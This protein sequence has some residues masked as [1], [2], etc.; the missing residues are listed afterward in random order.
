MVQQQQQ[1]QQQQEVGPVL[2]NSVVLWR[3][4]LGRHAFPQVLHAVCVT[5][6]ELCWGARGLQSIRFLRCCMQR[7]LLIGVIFAVWLNCA[8]APVARNP[9][10]L[11]MC[12]ILLSRWRRSS[13]CVELCWN[14][15]GLESMLFPEVLHAFCSPRGGDLHCVWNC[16]GAPVAWNPGDSSGVTCILLSL[17]G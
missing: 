13:L 2:K 1:Q 15:C 16:D 8:G 3:P 14:A 12:F 5:Y 4:W 11:R 17:W 10:F 9:C 6:G 7:A